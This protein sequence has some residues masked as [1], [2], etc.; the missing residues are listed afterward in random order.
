MKKYY[1]TYDEEAKINYCFLFALFLIAERNT[2]EH[3]DNVIIY[4]NQKELSGRIKDK[5]NYN[6]SASSISRILSN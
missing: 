3:L 5:C 2:K 6:I 1:L 4:D